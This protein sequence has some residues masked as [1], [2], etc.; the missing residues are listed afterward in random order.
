MKIA[1]A[2]KG[3]AGKT[4]TS[5]GLTL[6]L[7]EQGRRPLAVDADPN[8]CLGYYLGLPDEI[9]EN[10]RPLS[11][12]RELLAKRAGTE[13]GRGGMY[14]LAPPVTDLIEEYTVEADGLSLLAMGTVT[15]GGQ[16]CL[17]PE[18]SVLKTVLRELVDLDRDIVVDLVA[19]LEH[20]GRG[21][22]AAMNGLVVVTEPTR[23]GLRTVQ[24]IRSLAQGIGLTRI[25]VV[26][27]KVAGPEQRQLIASQLADLPVV[28]YVPSY[29]QMSQQGVFS[30][31]AGAQ[32]REDM[33]RLGEALQQ[34]FPE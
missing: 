18:N 2:G 29:P 30:G 8:N 17:C 3:G 24:R 25:V 12:L 32:F 31:E 15:E 34:A 9:T 20:L 10:I 28:G 4:T 21:T 7:A 33:S 6:W 23:P 19:G 5:A 13:P 27:N 16:G 22:V 26:A 14:A 11:D 1:V